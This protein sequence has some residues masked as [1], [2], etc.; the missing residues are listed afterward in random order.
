VNN[1]R[2][3]AVALVF[4]LIAAISLWFV[5]SPSEWRSKSPETPAET[6]P[7]SLP[8]KPAQSA[9]AKV[10]AVALNS[11]VPSAADDALLKLL[12][13][14]TASDFVVRG[15]IFLSKDFQQDGKL[16]H[17]FA[18]SAGPD[19][20]E[21]SKYCALV[22]VQSGAIWLLESK[23]ERPCQPGTELR[24]NRIGPQNFALIEKTKTTTDKTVT[25]HVGVYALSGQS[26][27][28]LL[29]VSKSAMKDEALDLR[30]G[31]KKSDKA[32]WSAFVMTLLNNELV[33]RQRYSFSYGAYVSKGAL[34][35]H[36]KVDMNKVRGLETTENDAE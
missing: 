33:A 32:I 22:L 17:I 30:I 14:P 4:T 5:W 20:H 35:P 9:K 26:A 3:F 12:Y 23:I 21:Q 13:G 24:W 15:K 25:V 11:I 6:G 31:F 36:S 18:S 10:S 34:S 2:F 28:P 29:E 1:V 27:Q 19:A 8:A 7:E 16:K